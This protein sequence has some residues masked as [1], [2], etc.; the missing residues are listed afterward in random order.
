[1]VRREHVRHASTAETFDK[2]E[3][4]SKRDEVHCPGSELDD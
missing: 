3:I 2:L 4:E 1:M